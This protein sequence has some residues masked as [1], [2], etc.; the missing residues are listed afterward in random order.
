MA[1]RRQRH[2]EASLFLDLPPVHE[3]HFYMRRTA[4]YFGR[5][6]IEDPSSDFIADDRIDVIP[7]SHVGCLNIASLYVALKS[8]PYLKNA[9]LP[10]VSIFVEDKPG[11]LTYPQSQAE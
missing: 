10:G 2:L 9:L 1:L 6:N 11:V 3:I 4:P 7:A 5:R 8:N